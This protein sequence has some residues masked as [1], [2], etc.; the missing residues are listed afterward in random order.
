MAH[1]AV[2][3]NRHIHLLAIEG[4]LRDTDLCRL[5]LQL[6]ERTSNGGGELRGRCPQLQF[7]YMRLQYL[8]M[9]ELPPTK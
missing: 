3:A 1:V 9:K 7:I 8:Q 2:D 6:V 5:L 4:R